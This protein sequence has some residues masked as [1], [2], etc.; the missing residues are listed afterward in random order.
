[1]SEL[2][3]A[4]R[5]GDELNLRNLLRT[6]AKDVDYRTPHGK[7]PLYEAATEGHARCVHL[8]LAANAA[9]DLAHSSG[10]TPLMSAVYHG[11]AVVVEVLLHAN[12]SLEC[13]DN[14]G[15]TAL[16]I[17]KA[18][19]QVECARLLY[20]SADPPKPAS[21]A[22]STEPAAAEQLAADTA[23]AEKLGLLPLL[24]EVGADD[25]AT[26]ERAARFF[27][28]EGARSFDDVAKYGLADDF[29][30]ALQLQEKRVTVAKLHDELRA[31]ARKGEG[32]IARVERLRAA[33]SLPADPAV[34]SLQG[35]VQ[36]AN[37]QLGL[38]ATGPLH[39]QVEAL[40]QTLGLD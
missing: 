10:T 5:A 14:S 29:I 39:V 25:A 2:Y 8:L 15:K 16:D 17:A 37:E 3:A 20:S 33:L 1:M 11:H 4:A 31:L 35:A 19:G 26:L 7:T 21:A 30:E 27:E 18:R 6:H 24:A 38:E 34:L 36:A 23:Q 9:V 22:P 28:K 40:F 32:L 12:A 13:A